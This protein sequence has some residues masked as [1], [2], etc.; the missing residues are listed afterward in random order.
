MLV[1]NLI[2][3]FLIFLTGL[4]ME[5]NRSFHFL[6]VRSQLTK[7]HQTKKNFMELL[8]GFKH[9]CVYKGKSHSFTSFN[10]FK[11]SFLA[12]GEATSFYH[13]LRPPLF[14]KNKIKIKLTKLTRFKFAFLKWSFFRKKMQTLFRFRRTF[15][16]I[17]QKLSSTLH[18]LMKEKESFFSLKKFCKT[19][20]TGI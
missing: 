15:K 6:F 10:D 14:L 2:S 11:S 16:Y 3:T 9:V 1:L 5:V 8:V 4:F 7:Q 12:Y 20:K 13:F 18:I 17:G 19:L